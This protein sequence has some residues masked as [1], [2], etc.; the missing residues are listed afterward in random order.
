V[1]VEG[2]SKKFTRG[3][4]TGLRF[5]DSWKTTCSFHQRERER[6]REREKHFVWGCSADW[7]FREI[8][9]WL[10]V[11]VNPHTHSAL[12]AVVWPRIKTP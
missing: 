6:E 2:C 5:D 4:I 7:A 3:V 8:V 12:L 11:V 10:M 9:N 1:H